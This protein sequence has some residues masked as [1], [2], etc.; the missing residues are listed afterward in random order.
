MICLKKTAVDA[1][2]A[3]T[4]EKEADEEEIITIKKGFR[5]TFM[6]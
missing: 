3:F 6:E 4:S 2:R 1:Q 5:Q